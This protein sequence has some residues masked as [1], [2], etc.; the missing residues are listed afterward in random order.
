LHTLLYDAC[1][2]HFIIL[3]LDP[4]FVRRFPHLCWKRGTSGA[5]YCDTTGAAAAAAEEEGSAY[6]P[7]APPSVA[8][9]PD[10]LAFRQQLRMRQQEHLRVGTATHRSGSAAAAFAAAAEAAYWAIAAGGAGGGPKGVTGA[11]KSD[12]DASG[13]LFVM[14]GNDQDTT[15]VGSVF[16]LRVPPEKQNEWTFPRYPEGSKCGEEARR[17]CTGS[18][19]L[20]GT[21]ACQGG[22][23]AA[24]FAQCVATAAEEG[25]GTKRKAKAKPKAAKEKRAGAS[26]IIVI[27]DSDESDDTEEEEEGV[28]FPAGLTEGSAE[29]SGLSVEATE[30]L[31][32][33]VPRSESKKES[34]KAGASAAGPDTKPCADAMGAASVP[35]VARAA[36]PNAVRF[37]D[38]DYYAGTD[39]NITNLPFAEGSLLRFLNE[40][41][42]G[43]TVPWL[44]LGMIFASFC[45]HSE[46]HYLY[47]VNYMACGEGKTWYGI[48]GVNAPDYERVLQGLINRHR[49]ACGDTTPLNVSELM[50][51]GIGSAERGMESGTLVH[52]LTTMVSPTQL[53]REKV[54]VY[55]LLQEPGQFVITFPQ[56][57]HAG[58]SH[59]FNVA[60]ACNF[61]LP[62]WLP[63]GRRAME[64]YRSRA[65]PRPM[66]FSQDQL[67]CDLARALVS[68]TASRLVVRD[69]ARVVE[70]LRA[71]VHYEERDR[72][73]VERKGIRGVLVGSGPRYECAV[74]SCICYLAAV[75]CA[76]CGKT[77]A[78]AEKKVACLRHASDMCAC[79]P[80]MLRA[81]YFIDIPEL[82]RL[83]QEATAL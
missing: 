12:E 16:P 48:P 40:E 8:L 6:G 18:N 10:A 51:M 27:E 5:D 15:Q 46:D 77:Q 28:A 76:Q 64:K 52:H 79:G 36:G 21:C 1:S 13:E 73:A 81:V 67:V 71:M 66:C 9:P 38:P 80:R 31:S 25:K 29:L 58:F 42:N 49:D 75:I 44:Y 72:L 65:T 53:A 59:G 19:G 33:S 39:W 2:L 54:P 4:Y 7:T 74:C 20:A 35:P 50:G 68:R 57:Y 56:A 11:G 14:Y 69:T 43:L 70:E 78:H 26:A 61:A 24:D 30:G 62:D 34:L 22:L 45:W 63:H 17:A 55:K 37:N 47:S 60:E 82:K 41:V 83:L 23:E 32:C 3:F